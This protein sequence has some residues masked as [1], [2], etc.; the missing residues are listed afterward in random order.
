MLTFLMERAWEGN[1][2]YV[3][4]G[5]TALQ[6]HGVIDRTTEDVDFYIPPR[7]TFKFVYMLFP[8]LNKFRAEKMIFPGLEDRWTN[9][10]SVE[11]ATKMS[12]FYCHNFKLPTNVKADISESPGLLEGDNNFVVNLEEGLQ[13]ASVPVLAVFKLCAICHGSRNGQAGHLTKDVNDLFDCLKYLTR[14]R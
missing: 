12:V 3:V 4:G 13:V 10:R 1:L 11:R 8:H 5:A 14:H 9:P 7:M 2:K 6:L